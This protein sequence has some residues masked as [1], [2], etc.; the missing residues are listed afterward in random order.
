M[1]LMKLATIF[2]KP[3]PMPTPA[4]PEKIASA[5]RLMPAALSTT[6][7][8]NTI[9]ASR[10]TLISSTWI[11]GVRSAE[12]LMRFSA[13]LLAILVSLAV[14][15]Q[16]NP[17]QFGFYPVCFFH[18][19]TGLLCPACGSLRA[20][21]RRRVGSLRTCPTTRR[22]SARADSLPR[23]QNRTL[24]SRPQGASRGRDA[25]AATPRL[26][27][28]QPRPRRARAAQ[29]GTTANSALNTDQPKSRHDARFTAISR[30]ASQNSWQYPMDSELRSHSSARHTSVRSGLCRCVHAQG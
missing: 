24:R 25:E 14:L 6:A 20:W 30:I 1:P 18:K 13:K 26:P 23:G 4:A 28:R 10:I 15:F 22:S 29:T 3:K 16:F 21:N 9:S 8:A 12:R 5:E 17:A 27:A 2:C 11:D 7:T 19:S